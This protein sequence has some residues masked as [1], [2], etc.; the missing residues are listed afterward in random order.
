[1][2]KEEA[3]AAAICVRAWHHAARA[4]DRE[5]TVFKV[6]GTSLEDL[7]AATLVWENA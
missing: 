5:H 4:N 1:M 3:R 7:T 2:K 6:V